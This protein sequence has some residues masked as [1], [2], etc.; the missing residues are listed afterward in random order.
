MSKL[1]LPHKSSTRFPF[2]SPLIDLFSYFYF[3]FIDNPGVHKYMADPKW[4]NGLVS[5]A[6]NVAE[7]V[8]ILIS[9]ANDSAQ[10]T[11]KDEALIASS[12]AVARYIVTNYIFLFYLLI[13]VS[14]LVRL[15]ISSLPQRPRRIRTRSLNAIS[16]APPRRSRLPL[17]IWS[18]LPPLLR[19]SYKKVIFILIRNIIDIIVDGYC[20]DE[21]E[22]APLSARTMGVTREL[23]IQMEVL[24]LEKDLERQRQKLSELRKSRYAK[25]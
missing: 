18:R 16:K 2:S 22:E 10:G 5:A 23:E 24:R 20:V 4:A 12:K 15:F 14:I 25:K 13:L 3:I 17:L 8:H 11:L 19:N 21:K 6:Q 9:S 7:S 1:P